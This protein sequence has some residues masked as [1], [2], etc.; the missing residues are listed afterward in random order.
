MRLDIMQ[1]DYLLEEELEEV[2]ELE[3]IADREKSVILYNDD[4]NT[5]EFVIDMLVEIC[6]HDPLQAEQC[7]LITHYKGKCAVKS[8]SPTKLKPLCQGLC[9][10][11]LSAVIE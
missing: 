3:A 9:D 2:I 11:G 6:H 5:F 1:P 4:V 10:K 7:A 8:G